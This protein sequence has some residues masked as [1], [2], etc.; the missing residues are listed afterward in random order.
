M[1]MGFEDMVMSVNISVVQ[2]R[3]KSI[4]DTIRRAL[5]ETGLSAQS[6]EIEVTESIPHWFFRCFH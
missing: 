6:L 2:L 1:N 4:I 3:H 5:A